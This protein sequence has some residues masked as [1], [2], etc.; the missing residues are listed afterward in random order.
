MF[1]ILITDPIS[2]HGLKIL[3]DDKIKII[4]KP[5]INE[6][7]LKAILSD[8][9]GWIIRSGTQIREKHLTKAKKLSVIGRAGVGVDNIDIDAATDN[10]IVVMNVP[11]GNTIS[12]AEHTMALIAAF[13]PCQTVQSRSPLVRCLRYRSS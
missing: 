7:E 2:D 9:N 5:N 13:L 11:D 10:G 6:D 8:I 12:A 3:D 1:K 4:Y